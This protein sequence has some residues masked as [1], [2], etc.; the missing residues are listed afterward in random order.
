MLRL[1]A[2]AV[3]CNMYVPR[4]AK[5]A[6][7][8]ARAHVPAKPETLVYGAMERAKCQIGP[9]HFCLRMSIHLV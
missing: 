7:W 6:A 9:D 8:M 3:P 1:G 4:L 2:M 5:Q